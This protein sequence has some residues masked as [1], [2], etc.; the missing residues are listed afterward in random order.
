MIWNQAQNYRIDAVG[1]STCRLFASAGGVKPTAQEAVPSQ[2]A[3]DLRFR[4]QAVPQTKMNVPMSSTLESRAQ[5]A[6]RSLPTGAACRSSDTHAINIV[7]GNHAYGHGIGEIL[8]T[9]KAFFSRLSGSYQVTYSIDLKPCVTNVL[10]DEFSIAKTVAYLREFKREHPGTKF[11]IVATEFITPIRLLGM[12][13]V[14]TFNYFDHWEDLGYG[15][16]M[17]AHRLG[18]KQQ[19]PYM[20]ARY[21]GFS[22]VL[23]LADLVLAVHPA[24]VEALMPLKAEMEHWVA[25]PINLYP[26]ISPEVALNPHLK[27][28]QA[29]FVT[30][31][32]QTPFRRQ[33][34]KK[35]LLSAKIVGIRGPVFHHL[36]FDRSDAFSVHNGSIDF[37]FEKR[38]SLDG[39]GTRPESQDD[40][41]KSELNYLFNLNPPQRANW[42]YSSPMRILRAVLYGQIP[43]ITQRFDDHEIE[44]IGKLW[45]PRISNANV[46]RELW[47]DATLGREELIDRH[48]AA[49]SEYN[50]IAKQKN[51]AVD[52]ALQ[53]L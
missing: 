26:E 2:E 51:A 43:V 31:G 42:P 49:I 48:V 24:I 3:D 16:A 36:P 18:L 11:V 5:D 8:Y 47:L 1:E 53:A 29:G 9:L 37:P 25:P 20:Y 38:G 32:T 33:I 28:W 17:I 50:E 12:Q 34:I 52:L 40:K 39:E 19:P 23:R 21:V 30:T 14:E 10:I 45:S 4:H 15:S 6:D 27:E 46:I 7:I 13:L 35:L 22:Q 44:A 41:G